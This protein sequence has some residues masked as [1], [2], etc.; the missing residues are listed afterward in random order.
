M[1]YEGCIWQILLIWS[2]ADVLRSDLWN[3]VPG[4]EAFRN[5]NP[6]SC[7]YRNTIPAA[8]WW[9]DCSNFISSIDTERTSGRR[10]TRFGIGGH[11]GHLDVS[12]ARKGRTLG[13]CR[14]LQHLHWPPGRERLQTTGTFPRLFRMRSVCTPCTLRDQR[15]SML[16]QVH[17]LAYNR[18]A[19]LEP[20]R[21]SIFVRLVR[22]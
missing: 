18:H 16:I 6:E 19:R 7:P 11:C 10:P 20:P 17:R 15:K 12:V 2:P 13:R 22:S 4:P 8:A 14:E 1:R 3:V 21:Y 9:N 5:L